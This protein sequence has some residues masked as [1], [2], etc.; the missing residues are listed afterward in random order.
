M[1]I[2][3]LHLQTLG[4]GIIRCYGSRDDMDNFFWDIAPLY[5]SDEAVAE[6]LF[7]KLV[8][9]GRSVMLGCTT[10]LAITSL[11]IL[12]NYET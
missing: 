11:P 1:N 3:R 12:H 10:R 9:L 8:L 2:I 5:A 6:H 4:Y 7:A